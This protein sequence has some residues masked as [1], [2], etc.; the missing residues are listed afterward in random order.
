MILMLKI[1]FRLCL[2]TIFILALTLS[3]F[4]DSSTREGIEKRQTNISS[5]S[6]S[7]EDG[8]VNT[9]EARDALR[10]IRAEAR[11]ANDILL[12]QEAVLKSQLDSLGIAP[13][14]GT[15]ELP[16]VSE[17]RKLLNQDLTDVTSL[18]VQARLNAADAGRL[19]DGLSQTQRQSFLFETF[20]AQQSVFAPS[21]WRQIGK[22]SKALLVRFPDHYKQWKAT[23][24]EL[25]VWSSDKLRTLGLLVFLMLLLWP[26]RLWIKRLFSARL[27]RAVPRDAGRYVALF[28]HIIVRVV[29]AA[30]GFLVLYQSLLS[31]QFIATEYAPTIRII[32]YAILTWLI[33]D[34]LAV[35]LFNPSQSAWR[36]IPV[37]DRAAKSARRLSVSAV[38]LLGLGWAITSVAKISPDM[39]PLSKAATF[40]MALGVSVIAFMASVTTKWCLI[41]ERI[42]DISEATRKRWK[43]VQKAGLPLIF[44]IMAALTLGYINLAYFVSVRMVLLI[45]IFLWV[46]VIRRYVIHVL[47]EFDQS[48][49]ARQANAKSSSRQAMLFWTGLV[50]DGFI[51]LALI[52]I[53]LL[54]LGTDGYSVRTG[55][56]DAFTGIT[57]GNFTLSIADI[58]AAITTFFVILFVTRFLQRVLDVRLF[59]KSGADIGFR[60]SFRT[61]LG[62][63]GL[64]IAIFAAIGVIGLDLSNLAIIAGALSVGIGF[65][66]QSIVNNFVSGLILLFERPVKVGDWVVTT[67][68]EGVVKQISVRSTEIETFDR[69]SIIVPN[70]ELISSSVTNWTHKNKTGR[71]VVPVGIAYGSDAKRVREILMEIANRN[72]RV[73]KTPEPFVYFKEFGESSLDLEL[74]VFIKN[75]SD[76]PLVRNDLRFEILD[77]FREESIEIPFPQR[78]VHLSKSICFG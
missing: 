56:I 66:L 60:N 28:L 39:M 5:I 14:E 34:G 50:L 10:L 27:D 57:I 31:T 69:A 25:G 70:S 9:I 4:A 20:K 6:K 65:G 2:S 29:P 35:G 26:L 67:S 62:Y 52:P 47:N 3:A 51:L 17:R 38:I 42:A 22:S 58:L 11:T 8:N 1:P 73:L 33:A 13:Q 59:E 43:L 78:D 64:I 63:A 18:M 37:Q 55:L 71:V 36:I 7:L 61:L 19:L 40:I 49:L 75:I 12:K 45:G 74:R 23:R 16:E 30:I 15:T 68:G 21:Q 77:V 24:S 44:I 76:G 48:V 41:D 32:I 46:W 72:A 53:L 54:I